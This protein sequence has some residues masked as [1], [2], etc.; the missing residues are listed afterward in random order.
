[1]PP[2]LSFAR[3]Y[4]GQ[5]LLDQPRDG[6]QDVT[7]DLEIASG[8][9]GSPI[10]FWLACRWDGAPGRYLQSLTLEDTHGNLLS[11]QHQGMKMVGLSRRMQFGLRPLPRVQVTAVQMTTPFFGPVE[12]VVSVDGHEVQRGTLHIVQEV[13]G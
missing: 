2:F 8:G 3:C 10:H 4:V 13:V 11:F 7:G 5:P 1:M 12:W 6:E 9:L